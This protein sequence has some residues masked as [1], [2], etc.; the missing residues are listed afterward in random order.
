MLLHQTS[1]PFIPLNKAKLQATTSSSTKNCSQD[2]HSQHI[3]YHQA[4]SQTTNPSSRSK[5]LHHSTTSPADEILLIHRANTTKPKT[6]HPPPTHLSP[7]P[8]PNHPPQPTHPGSNHA[9]HPQHRPPQRPAFPHVPSSC[10]GR[11]PTHHNPHNAHDNN[12]HIAPQPPRSCA[13][14]Y[15][16][17][18]A[19][20]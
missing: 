11:S 16:C 1:Q 9:P 18:S 5:H 4:Y 3:V 6:N 20:P 17:T 10:Q 7:P 15:R 13:G 2:Q 19:P 12:P 8:P 14:H